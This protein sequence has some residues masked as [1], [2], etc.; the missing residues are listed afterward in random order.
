[1][2]K[3]LTENSVELLNRFQPQFKYLPFGIIATDKS[4]QII[5]FNEKAE[6]IFG[7]KKEEILRINPSEIIFSRIKKVFFEGTL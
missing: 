3:F 6:K 2:K 1:L 4:F 7:Y 5:E